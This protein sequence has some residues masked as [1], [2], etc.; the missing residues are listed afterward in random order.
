MTPF[1]TSGG[2]GSSLRMTI[3]EGTALGAMSLPPERSTRRGAAALFTTACGGGRRR[4]RHQKSLREP[5]QV[6]GVGE[7][8]RRQKKSEQDENVQAD[9]EKQPRGSARMGRGTRLKQGLGEK[10]APTCKWDRSD[11][12]LANRAGLHAK[13]LRCCIVYFRLAYRVRFDGHLRYLHLQ[14]EF[15]C[16]PR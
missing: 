7:I 6:Q 11:L 15:R 14:S 13:T 16:S 5:F 12:S 8:E 9:R 1:P 3:L 10:V 4:R 2:S